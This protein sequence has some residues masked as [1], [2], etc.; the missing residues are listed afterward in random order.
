MTVYY[1]SRADLEDAIGV[2]I[3][4]A[5]FDEDSSGN[6]S[7]RAID[8]C[9]AYGTSECNSFLRSNYP[10]GKLPTEEDSVP[11]ELLFAAIDFGCV[12]AARRRPDLVNAMGGETWK[13]F[14]DAANAKMQRYVDGI[15]RVPTATGVPENVQQSVSA[16]PDVTDQ[17]GSALEVY[18]CNSHSPYSR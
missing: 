4:K 7:I 1:F 10:E 12:Y 2:Q 5:I 18:D 11:A 15:Q 14:L 17:S 13:T 16:G 6:P 9:R 3:V 8:S